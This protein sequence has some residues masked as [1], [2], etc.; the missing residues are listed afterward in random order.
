MKI[1]S[2]E[3]MLKAGVHFGHRT[4]RWH[5]NMEPFIF[6]ERGG[7]HII[8][9]EL[10][11]K[12]LE[13]TLAIAKTFASQGKT[14]LFVGTK[15]QGQEIVKKYAKEAGMPYMVERWIGGLLTNFA[16]IS[17]VIK[18]FNK[19]RE[20]QEKGEWEK[21]TK[22]EQLDLKRELEKLT[23]VVEGVAELTRK[24]DLLF[25]TDLRREKTA[26]TE[27]IRTKIEV[28]GVCDTNANPSRANYII[29][30]NDDAVK[31]IEMMVAAVAGAI[32][33]G[34]KEWDKKQAALPTKT[35]EKKTVKKEALVVASSE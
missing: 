8:N 17:K 3:D 20:G 32:K 30:A 2:L 35:V 29:P 4:S 27:A 23:P 7:V 28:I 9:L 12:K 11:Q 34:K 18:K 21:F 26:L 6:G 24:P 13:D 31:S 10:T 25:V 22:R 14:I 5:P 33:E 15:K 19:L 1:P 16:E